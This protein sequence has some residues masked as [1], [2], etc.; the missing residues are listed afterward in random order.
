MDPLQDR[1]VRVGLARL[2]RYGFALAGGYALQAHGLVQ[3]MSEDI[4]LFTDHRD[5]SHFVEAIEVVLEAYQEGGLEVTVLQQTDT[6]A[7]LQA[8]EPATGATATIDLAADARQKAP[9]R[10]ELGPVLA[11]TDAVA[12]KVAAVFSRGYARDYIDLAGIL[13]SGRYRPE[14]LMGMA[15]AVDPG[16]VTSI[17]AEALAAVDRFPDEEFARYGL[18]AAQITGVRSAMRSWSAQLQR[19]APTSPGPGMAAR[20]VR[21]SRPV[22]PPEP[23]L[24]E[25]PAL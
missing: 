4:D 2:D 24:P 10:V 18:D 5:P 7:R 23:P 11:E 15:S 22:P 20:P 17:F 9:I 8:A 6:F 14:Q 12:S 13:A 25:G 21:P 3:R 16:F 19:E 1:L